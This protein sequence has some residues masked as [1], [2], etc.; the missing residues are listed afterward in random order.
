M[1]TYFVASE[2]VGADRATRWAEELLIRRLVG[3]IECDQIIAQT[4]PSV[5]DTRHNMHINA[6]FLFN[7]QATKVT[8]I[9]RHFINQN[10]CFPPK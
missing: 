1:G 6:L 3:M 8:L 2:G 5:G 10:I 4:A 7:P 9:G